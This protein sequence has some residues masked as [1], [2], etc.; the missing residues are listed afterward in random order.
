MTLY[1]LGATTVAGYRLRT[2]D[3]DSAAGAVSASLVE[4]EQ[5]LEEE[6][7]RKLPLQSR[8]DAFPIYPDGRIYPDAWPITSADLTIE[9]R[10]LLGATPDLTDFVAWL[11]ETDCRRSGTVTWT[12][13]FDA[14]SLP[15][16]LAHAVYDLARGLILDTPAIPVG[17]SVSVGD[18]SVGASPGGTGL[19]SYTPG[20]TG[21]VNRYRNRFV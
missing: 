20:I 3:Q 8:T 5:L 16:T 15:M 14:S 17:V 6:L 21:R 1:S 2:G 13:G 18:V 4:S 11:G 7:R 19:D 10:A 9:G 12:G